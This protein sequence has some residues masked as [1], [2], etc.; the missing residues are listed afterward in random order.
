MRRR[1]AGSQQP[2]RSPGRRTASA[3]SALLVAAVGLAGCGLP[4]EQ[5]TQV[6][7]DE[8]VPYR[9]LEP[10]TSLPGSTEASPRVPR[11]TA[12]VFWV[13]R[14]DLLTSSDAGLTCDA[15]ATSVVGDV[16]S[17]LTA[18][19]TVAERSAGLS[20]AIPSTAGLTLVRIADG[21]A[22]IDVDPVT[23][24]D[25]EQLPL[26]VGQIV[27][28]TTTAPGVTAVRLVTSG[29]PVDVPLP[30]GALAT[31]EVTP[32]DYAP[33]LPDRLADAVLGS[34]GIGCAAPGT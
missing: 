27:L 33:L 16:L 19:P 22:E 10:G 8:A 15:T 32:E 24:G 23:I 13:D 9:L 26:A 7:D 4:D 12:V 18:N 6:V 2:R 17:A 25:A 30:G 21:V 31:G 14:G 20:S 3:A 11:R 34:G 5:R 1:W 28:S 29:H